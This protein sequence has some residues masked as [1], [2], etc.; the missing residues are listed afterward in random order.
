MFMKKTLLIFSLLAMLTMKMQAQIVT[1]FDGNVYQT[2]SIGT[3]VWMVENLKVT[4]YRNG[5]PITNIT[6]N[7]QWFN[8]STPAYCDYENTSGNSIIYGRIYNYFAV[9]DNRKIA[10]VGWH[11]PTDAEWTI[12][13]DYLTNNGYGNGGSGPAIAKSMASKSGWT[14]FLQVGTTGN[15]QASNNSSGFSALPGG[16]RFTSGGFSDIGKSCY[17]WSSTAAS[18]T[19]GWSRGINYNGSACGRGYYDNVRGLSVRCISDIGVPTNA[20]KNKI[21]IDIELY[22]NPAKEKIFLTISEKED[23]NLTIYNLVGT[24]ILRKDLRNGSNEIN[25]TSL[26]K[27]I[28]VVKLSGADWTVQKKLI[29]E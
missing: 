27:G 1:D 29:K 5:D 10:P 24:C 8:L 21:D 13:T 15:D 9:A 4:H 23:I 14:T 16:G 26:S 22:P 11:V 12:L 28:Y 6:D 17:L 3:Q 25:I 20:I 19:S 7:H 2:I 18:L